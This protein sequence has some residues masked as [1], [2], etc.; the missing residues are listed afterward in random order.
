MLLLRM[1][2]DHVKHGLSVTMFNKTEE[3]INGADWE[4]WKSLQG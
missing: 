1:A 3:G 4:L 2:R